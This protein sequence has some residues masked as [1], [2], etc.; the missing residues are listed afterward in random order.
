MRE[1]QGELGKYAFAYNEYEGNR[2]YGMIEDGQNWQL[3][4]E[5]IDTLPNHSSFLDVSCG[6]G[7]TLAMATARGLYANGT[8]TVPELCGE[9]VTRAVLPNL[10][11]QDKQYDYVLNLDVMEHIEPPNVPA[12]LSEIVRVAAKSARIVIDSKLSTLRDPEDPSIFH[13][14]HIARFPR[15]YW[16]L[17]ADEVG[18]R[19]NCGVHYRSIRE[20]KHILTFDRTVM[21]DEGWMVKY[22]ADR[23]VNCFYLDKRFPIARIPDHDRVSRTTLGSTWWP[24]FLA[25]VEKNGLRS[26]VL[27]HNWYDPRGKQP[28]EP[29]WIRDGNH[30]VYA[31]YKLGWETIPAVVYG[32]HCIDPYRKTEKMDFKRPPADTIEE[33]NQ[34]I[35]DGHLEWETLRNGIQVPYLVG[36]SKPAGEFGGTTT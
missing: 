12:C 14:L 19:Y 28:Q 10:P 13:H 36:A 35:K 21:Y 34:W 26:P 24:R 25:D 17:C 32:M 31:A 29:F 15:N 1:M 7:E 11:F 8:E 22:R 2:P 33:A 23:S 18:K 27:L 20:Y 3:A 30:R 16:M 5:Y 6:R 4:K 9:R